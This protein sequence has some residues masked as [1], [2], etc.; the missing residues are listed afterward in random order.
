MATRFRLLLLTFI[1]LFFQRLKVL[2]AISKMSTKC[3]VAINN[4]NLKSYRKNSSPL[5][6]SSSIFNNNNRNNN[7]NDKLNF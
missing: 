7:N 6:C 5:S 3:T 2:R 4:K 1:A